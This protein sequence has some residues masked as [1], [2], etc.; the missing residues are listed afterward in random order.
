MEDDIPAPHSDRPL[1]CSLSTKLPARLEQHLPVRAR[2]LSGFR[3]RTDTGSPGVS[4]MCKSL[5]DIR[6]VGG[7]FLALGRNC[8]PINCHTNTDFRDSNYWPDPA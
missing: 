2:S 8:S 7:P 1:P 5:R 6:D 4:I 3:L